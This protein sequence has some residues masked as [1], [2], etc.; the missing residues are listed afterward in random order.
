MRLSCCMK[1]ISSPCTF[2]RDLHDYQPE[3]TPWT[4]TVKAL[5]DVV[6]N[7][8]LQP[9]NHAVI[10]YYRHGEDYLS[11]TSSPTLDL[12]TDSSVVK[13]SLGATRTVILRPKRK[14]AGVRRPSPRPTTKVVLKHGSLLRL[15]PKTNRFMTHEIKRISHYPSQASKRGSVGT[16]N[17]STESGEEQRIS[18]HVRICITFRHV[19]TFQTDDGRIFG[20]GATGSILGRSVSSQLHPAKKAALLRTLKAAF[21]Q[22]SRDTDFDRIANYSAGFDVI[23]HQ[24]V[25]TVSCKDIC[26]FNN[27]PDCTVLT[28]LN[29]EDAFSEEDDFMIKTTSSSDKLLHYGNVAK[30]LSSGMFDKGKFEDEDDEQEKRSYIPFHHAQHIFVK[31]KLESDLIPEPSTSGSRSRT[32]SEASSAF[33]DD[34]QVLSLCPTSTSIADMSVRSEQTCSVNNGVALLALDLQNDFLSDD[35]SFY[36]GKKGSPFASRREGLLKRI[37]EIA[38]EVRRL[39]GVVFMVKSQYGAWSSP[40]STEFRRFSE[41]GA[42]MDRVDC[43]GVSSA[44]ADF[45]PDV[46]NMIVN[47][48]IILIKE[49]HS[50]FMGT[51]L[52]KQLQRLK[53]GHV[54]VCGVTTDH[55]VA[56]TVRSAANLGYN[57]ILSSDGTAQ[58]NT[59]MQQGTERRLSKYYSKL[60][61]KRHSLTDFVAPDPFLEALAD[62]G[63]IDMTGSLEIDA[64]ARL[65]GFGA[66]DSIIGECLSPLVYNLSIEILDHTNFVFALQSPTFWTNQALWRC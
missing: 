16:I 53:V 12:F 22:E 2:L 36:Y 62:P 17:T 15:G 3:L 34:E 40:Q 19:A 54:V 37:A 4:P 58:A 20:K 29:V 24:Y 52:D 18:E 59:K 32:F 26:C 47:Q 66:G 27:D 30:V 45:H 61:G 5:R 6:S 31:R 64:Y 60:L 39:G 1:S 33:A 50:A 8:V 28:S 51:T 41:A 13:L 63:P 56:A 43:C 7:I 35:P 46:E 49:W 14:S 25:T 55:S 10:C 44:G 57:V 21:F 48:D 9:L 65:S 42:H 23:P 11:E 38:N